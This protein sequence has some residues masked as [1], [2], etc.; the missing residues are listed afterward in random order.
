MYQI[1]VINLQENVVRRWSKQIKLS[2]ITE[3]PIGFIIKT[4]REK[5]NHNFRSINS[6]IENN[7]LVLLLFSIIHNNKN[8]ISVS[9]NLV[10]NCN[11]NFYNR[12]TN[13]H[14]EFKIN[15]FYN[16]VKVLFGVYVVFKQFIGLFIK[17][18]LHKI[19]LQRKFSTNIKVITVLY[20][21]I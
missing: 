6:S 14:K 12:L 5:N 20:T 21:T 1:R 4:L 9:N 13:A 17:Y 10:G 19:R 2:T 11:F 3:T 7:F 18:Q 15:S 8:K 16:I